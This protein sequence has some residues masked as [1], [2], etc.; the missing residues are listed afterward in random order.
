MSA[1]TPAAERDHGRYN[2]G[3]NYNDSHNRYGSEPVFSRSDREAI[4]SCVSDNYGNL[5]PGLAKRG[6]NLPPGLEKQVQRNGQL[7]PGLQKRVQ[8]MPGAC[9]ARLPR[10]PADWARVILGRRVILLDPAQRII[11]LFNLDSQD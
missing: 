11:D 9:D 7:P 8:P 1:M 5:P 2:Q 10:L 3:Q 6:G 4:R